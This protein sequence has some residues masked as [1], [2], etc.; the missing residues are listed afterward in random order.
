MHLVDPLPWRIAKTPAHL[1]T[2]ARGLGGKHVKLLSREVLGKLLQ[3]VHRMIVWMT[4]SSHQHVQRRIQ[5]PKFLRR[6]VVKKGS[7]KMTVLKARGVKKV[8]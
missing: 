4:L 1:A 2:R 5:V 7:M 8:S 6:E 3:H